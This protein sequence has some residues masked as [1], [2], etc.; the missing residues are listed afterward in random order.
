MSAQKR[1]TKVPD[2]TPLLSL[3]TPLTTQELADLTTTPPLGYTITPPETNLHTW[4]LHLHGPPSTPFSSG[5]FTLT[6]TFPPS[7]PFAP[8]TLAFN[9]KIYHPNV[10]NDDK[11]S[12]CLGILRPDVW[13][14]SCR[15]RDVL[16]FARGLL[17]EPDT[18]DAVEGGIAGEIKEDRG[19]W[20]KKAK[21]W[22]GRY[23][24][25]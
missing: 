8:P 5:V 21:E 17:V 9:T 12:M 2:P 13:K 1:I 4:T 6:L 11:G 7:Y 18:E 3:Y 16:D 25:G 22:T 14:P 23:A 24:K 15:V 19:A 20:E 10:T